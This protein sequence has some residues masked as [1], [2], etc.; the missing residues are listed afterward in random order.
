M[1]SGTSTSMLKVTHGGGAHL[2]WIKVSPNVRLPHELQCNV[3]V[4]RFCHHLEA[5]TDARKAW[6]V[7]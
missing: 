2:G 7:I 1:D 4:H 5:T 6:T 3:H